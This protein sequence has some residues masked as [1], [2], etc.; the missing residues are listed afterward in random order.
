MS[1]ISN[2]IRCTP[3]ATATSAIVILPFEK[4]ES[5]STPSTNAFAVAL[6]RPVALSLAVFSVT[7]ADTVITLLLVVTVLYFSRT[8]FFS[9]STRETLPKTG[10][11][12][13]STAAEKSAVILS[14]YTVCNPLIVP[15]VFHKSFVFV[16]GNI[17]SM[18]RKLLASFLL[19]LYA[20]FSL[21]SSPGIRIFS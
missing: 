9:V 1:Q 16:C 15:Y 13:S 20:I 10:A 5:T 8:V 4:I 14:T 6:S 3:S 11:S 19:E 7:A 2:L 21:Q 18:K 12:L 17:N